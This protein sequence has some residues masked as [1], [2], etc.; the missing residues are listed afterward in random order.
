M[1]SISALHC[2]GKLLAQTEEI[3]VGAL[4]LSLN[5]AE[6]GLDTRISRTMKIHV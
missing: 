3:R 1:Q 2:L 5:S 4:G 6:Y